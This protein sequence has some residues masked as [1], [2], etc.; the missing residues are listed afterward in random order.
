LFLIGSQGYTG[1]TFSTFRSLN[2]NYTNE[3]INF[4]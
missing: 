1:C 4:K 2:L 3:L